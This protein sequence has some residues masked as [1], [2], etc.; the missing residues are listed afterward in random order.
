MA[1]HTQ[2]DSAEDIKKLLAEMSSD[3]LVEVYQDFQRCAAIA[4]RLDA[5]NPTMRG[6]FSGTPS[7]RI[8]RHLASILK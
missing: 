3:R 8:E 5:R 4:Q 2:V 1:L 7:E 6:A